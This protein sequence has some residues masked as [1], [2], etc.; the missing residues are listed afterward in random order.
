MR[1]ASRGAGLVLLALAASGCATAHQCRLPEVPLA[2]PP[3]PPL[4]ARVGVAWAPDLGGRTLT[5]RSGEAAF[6]FPVGAAA[7][8]TFSRVA[9]QL[10]LAPAAVTSPAPEAGGPGVLELTLV[11]AALARGLFGS[12][13]A[14]VTVTGVL[15]GGAGEV[16]RASATARAKG[17][18]AHA[19]GLYH[20]DSGGAALAGGLAQ[21]AAQVRDALGASPAVAAWVRDPARGPPPEEATSLPPALPQPPASERLHRSYFV[22]RYL[23]AD[24][25]HGQAWSSAPGMKHLSGSGWGMRMA[26]DLGE[27]LALGM[28]AAV[29]YVTVGFTPDP[30]QAT[31]T[32]EDGF[33]GLEAQWRFRP[34]ERLRPWLGLTVAYQ[35]PVW[36]TYLYSVTGWSL[37]ASTGVDVY[38]TSWGALRLGLSGSTFTAT[39]RSSV[40]AGPNPGPG[41]D[42]WSTGVRSLW[43]TAGWLFDLGPAR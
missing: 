32:A 27:R 42:G 20:C 10:F 43:L 36:D 14:E 4:P 31:D 38:V 24:L 21:A 28:H 7:A 26:W 18:P 9:G 23:E 39:T 16:A 3:G 37:V 2:A 11:E 15:R 13:T 12:E 34:G 30:G 40:G 25:V 19:L 35:G 5:A 41:E 22:P 29:T 8:D 17:E 1:A 6:T 33:V